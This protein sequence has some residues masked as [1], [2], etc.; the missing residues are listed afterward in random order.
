MDFCVGDLIFT[1]F[2]GEPHRAG[3]IL[4]VGWNSYG[5][6]SYLTLLPDGKQVYFRPEQIITPGELEK[7]S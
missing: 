7:E 5:I 6:T 4:R 2:F 1:N 3:I